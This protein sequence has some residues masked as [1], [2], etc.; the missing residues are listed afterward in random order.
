MP[1]VT[2]ARPVLTSQVDLPGSDLGA[3]DGAMGHE[4]KFA[5]VC[6][7]G[8]PVHWPS[9]E[10]PSMWRAQLKQIWCSRPSV[11]T[12]LCLEPNGLAVAEPFPPG[13]PALS[14][15]LEAVRSL[16]LRLRQR[17]FPGG[18]TAGSGG[19]EVT[20]WRL[21]LRARWLKEDWE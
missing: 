11:F 13:F 17:P 12:A 15:T 4:T 7:G 1:C 19:W 6:S 10:H 5:S 20:S 3:E 16:L 9:A 18:E 14:A 2:R 21:P 8:G